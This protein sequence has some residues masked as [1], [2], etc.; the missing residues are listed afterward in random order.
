MYKNNMRRKREE[1]FDNT[2]TVIAN[3]II[4]LMK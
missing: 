4:R 1:G 3:W 2:V